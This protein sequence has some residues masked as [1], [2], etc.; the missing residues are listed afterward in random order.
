MKNE[1]EWHK[2]HKQ[3]PEVFYKESCSKKICKTQS[4][5]PVPESLYNKV[6]S[7]SATLLKKDSSTVVFLWTLRN[8]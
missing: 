2:H 4:K 7:Q 6:A 5:T 8:F 3:P 1:D